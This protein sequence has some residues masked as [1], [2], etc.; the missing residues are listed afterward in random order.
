MFRI[1]YAGKDTVH[2]FWMNGFYNAF[3]HW[4]SS[5]HFE[6]ECTKFCKHHPT[7]LQYRNSFSSFGSCRRPAGFLVF[8]ETLVALGVLSMKISQ[9]HKASS[10]MLKL[11]PFSTNS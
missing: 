4:I 10:K 8:V 3:A 2:H 5:G 1:I 6:S 7:S 9:A 11:Q